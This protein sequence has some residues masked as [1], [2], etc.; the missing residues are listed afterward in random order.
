MMNDY[1]SGDLMAAIA[2]VKDGKDHH[3]MEFYY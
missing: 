1:S 3:Y 2:T